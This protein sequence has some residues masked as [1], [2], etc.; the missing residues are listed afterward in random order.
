VLPAR[1]ET[2]PI[3]LYINSF[4]RR[5]SSDVILGEGFAGVADKAAPWQK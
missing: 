1:P 3:A 2:H 5:F 4:I